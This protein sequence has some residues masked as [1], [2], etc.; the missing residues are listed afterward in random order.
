MFEARIAGHGANVWLV[1]TGWSGGPCGVGRRMRIAWTRAMVRAALNG[2]LD[3][4]PMRIDPVF[5]VEAPTA[6]PEVPSE[7]LDPRCTWD[8]KAAYDSQAARLARMYAENF[9]KYSGSVAAE[10]AAAGPQARAGG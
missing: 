1:N 4:I 7:L 2:A 8:D 5:R 9:S 10:I 6:C 3:G